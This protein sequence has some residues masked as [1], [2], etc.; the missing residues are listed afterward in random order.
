MQQ[1]FRNN[2]IENTVANRNVDMSNQVKHFNTALQH[3]ETDRWRD[4]NANLFN[5]LASRE[6]GFEGQ[7]MRQ[8]QFNL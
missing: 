2:E 4:V 6:I 1:G 3:Q 7:H 5:Q 8:R